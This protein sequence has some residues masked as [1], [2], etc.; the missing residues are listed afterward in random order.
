VKVLQQPRRLG[1]GVCFEDAA[2]D[3]DL[4]A[5][6][7][8]LC[9]GTGYFG[10]FEAEFIR[11]GDRRLLIDF[12][13]RYYN[14]MGFEIARGLP[15]PL[16]VHAAAS[17]DE[18][19]LRAAV[20]DAQATPKGAARIYCHR[21]ALAMILAAQRLSGRMCAAEV[22]RWRAW[23]ARSR[24]Y[25]VDAAFRPQDLLPGFLATASELGRTLR[26]P[27]AFFRAIVLNE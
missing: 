11:K 15:L 19:R 6:L 9:R 2:L 5:A 13:P 23:Y 4:A 26:H 24:R 8:A 17:R 20:R 7:A 12:N 14:Q 22:E 10:V 16:L 21:L 18:P 1:I 3:P 27:R 25:A